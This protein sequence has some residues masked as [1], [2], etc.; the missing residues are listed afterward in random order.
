MR[1]HTSTA[2]EVVAKA[3]SVWGVIGITNWADLSYA[4]AALYTALLLGHWVWK[5]LIK[6]FRR[7]KQGLV[8]PAVEAADD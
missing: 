3:G 5:N 4:L 1:D 6:P 7:R 2:T 8:A